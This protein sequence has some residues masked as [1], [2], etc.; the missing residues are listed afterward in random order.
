MPVA[1]VLAILIAHGGSAVQG[2][3]HAPRLD[4][5]EPAIAGLEARLVD[6]GTRIELDAGRHEVVVLGY[7]GEPF[8]LIDDGGVFE[9]ALSPSTYLNRS[10]DGDAIP[11]EAD[12]NLDPRWVAIDDGA[13]ARWHDHA[14]HAPPGQELGARDESQ[15]RI[16]IRVDGRDAHIVGRVVTLPSASA[17]PWF[18]LAAIAA[19]AAVVSSAFTGRRTT[20]ALLGSLLVADVVRVWSTTFGVPTWLASRWDVVN[21]E[22]ASALVGW[23]MVVVALVLH[24]RHRGFEAAAASVVGAAV[25]ALNGG[26]LE[27][28]DLSTRNLMAAL[29][30]WLTRASIALVLGLGLGIAM[31]S[32]LAI[33]RQSSTP[34]LRAPRSDSGPSPADDTRTVSPSLPA[35]D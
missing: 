14:L 12:A 16:P 10:L 18:V 27:V 29:P 15:W 35:S 34:T 28:D 7:Q 21:D 32:L 17:T 19:V 5:V 23:G 26:A 30:G 31:R 1:F 4:G 3:D 33:T 22:W 20:V 2:S 25:L 8:L 9:N 13:V 11:D 6:A 24:A